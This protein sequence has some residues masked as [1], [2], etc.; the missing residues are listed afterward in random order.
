VT[1]DERHEDE[2]EAT[3]SSSGDSRDATQSAHD[4]TSPADRLKRWS[5]PESRWGNPEKD[6]PNIPRVA[7]PGQESDE[8]LESEFD[9][10]APE[11]TVDI[12]PEQSR[13]FWASVVLANIGL[14][15]ISLGPMLIYFRGQMLVGAGVTLVGVASLARVYTMYQEYKTHEWS[16]DDEDASESTDDRDADAE[17]TTDA[18]DRTTD[19]DSSAERNR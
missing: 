16:G 8:S 1:D 9:D 18:V 15:G 11:F 14:A 2:S 17:E 12:D 13:L 4:V 6:L 3:D 19:P 7:I 10:D 5:D